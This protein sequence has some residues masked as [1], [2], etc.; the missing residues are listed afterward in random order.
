MLRGDLQAMY[1]VHKCLEG[2]TLPDK[3]PQAFLASVTAHARTAVQL[4]HELTP[5]LTR[6]SMNLQL[7]QQQQP[8]RQLHQYKQPQPQSVRLWSHKHLHLHP[9]LLL[10]LHRLR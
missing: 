8:Q 7:L 10:H 4:P 3:L 5:R 6:M 1:L 9:W 2:A